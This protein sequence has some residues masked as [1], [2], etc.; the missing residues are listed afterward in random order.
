[1]ARA[2]LPEM[3]AHSCGQDCPRYFR[4]AAAWDASTSL[5]EEKIKKMF[6]FLPILHTLDL[7]A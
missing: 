3:N 5:R 7:H 2:I 1:V 4:A 6:C